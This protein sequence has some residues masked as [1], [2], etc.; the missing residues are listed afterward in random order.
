MVLIY[1]GYIKPI[2]APDIEH[3]CVLIDNSGKIAA[4]GRN[5]EAP[6][7]AK[8]IDAGSRLVTPG[9]VEAHCHVGISKEGQDWQ[10][11]DC[12]ELTDPITP[13][14]RAI[15]GYKLHDSGIADGIRGG[16]TTVCVTPGSTNVI[17]GTA[18]VIKL[19]GH[20]MNDMI[21]C[22][23]A[24]M[25]CAFGENP[26]N[27]H[28]RIGKHSPSS[29]L[30]VA[31]MLRETLRRAQNYRDAIA[32]GNHPAFDAQL[33]ALLPVVNGEMPI[34]AHVHDSCD[35]LSAIRIAKEF[36]LKMTLD[37][38]SC[39]YEIAEE[40][41]EA[42]YPTLVGP[43]V[44]YRSKVELEHRDPRTAAALYRFGAKVSII[45]DSPVLDL[46]M[47]PLCAGLA[48]SQGLPMDEAWKAITINP[49]EALGV[50]DRV[51]SL[52]VGKDGDVVIWTADPLTVIGGESYITL[53]NGEIV[54]S[55]E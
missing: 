3:G 30:G 51:G 10:G 15:D 46:N 7:G 43:V 23:D 54:Y 20:R 48:A 37:H 53:V 5:L 4:I 50:S 21:L 49:A 40:V 44:G 24:A 16:V 22:E 14:L 38:C 39:A 42:G 18:M 25:K 36:N 32:A 31:G 34:K 26:I 11:D 47:L 9:C 8:M 17:G 55:A 28:G 33:E 2:N 1:N 41:A 35:I 6:K 52:E 12:N 29:R 27:Y 45:T 19:A 13:N